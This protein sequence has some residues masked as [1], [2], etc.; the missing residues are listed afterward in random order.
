LLP[1]F[2]L[3]FRL[4]L[5]LSESKPKRNQRS[6]VSF[7]LLYIYFSLAYLTFCKATG[8]YI[9]V[10]PMLL[11]TQALHRHETTIA[12]HLF[13]AVTSK[14]HMEWCSASYG[15][16]ATEEPSNKRSLIKNIKPKVHSKES[17]SFFLSLS[18]QQLRCWLC[19]CGACY[20][21]QAKFNWKTNATVNKKCN[22]NRNSN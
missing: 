4:F 21:P 12:P 18:M 7:F 13:Q 10:K 22:S 1:L 19:L 3:F 20:R 9:I 2:S 14:G 15:N 11:C 6:P 8:Q 17:K 5:L 16:R